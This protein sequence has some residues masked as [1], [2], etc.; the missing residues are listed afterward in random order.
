[1]TRP[2]TFNGMTNFLMLE[3]VPFL[4][5]ETKKRKIAK[6][7]LSKESSLTKSEAEKLLK[8]KYGKYYDVIKVR[9][10]SN[11]AYWEFGSMSYSEYQERIGDSI[12]LTLERALRWHYIDKRDSAFY[13]EKIKQDS[14]KF[15]RNIM[16]RNSNDFNYFAYDNS[17]DSAYNKRILDSLNYKY[18]KRQSVMQTY[19]FRINKLGWINCDRFYD[20]PNKTDFVINLPKNTDASKFVT[21]LV[22]KKIKSV[23][24][25]NYAN[26]QIGFLSV[27][28]K[29]DVYLV[30][31]GESNGKI[32]SFIQPYKI[33]K[34]EVFINNLDE[35]TPTKFREQ[36]KQFNL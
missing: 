9:R 33:S 26:N 25:G 4:V 13:A 34:E 35:T 21:Q 15:V 8:A 17:K 22:F 14:L 7:L 2:V 23:L 36:L 29:M 32:Y 24:S 30:G 18:S 5:K 31:L 1:M 6:F 11:V 3:D 12:M 28:E 20:Y 19:D 16:F 27:P 10:H